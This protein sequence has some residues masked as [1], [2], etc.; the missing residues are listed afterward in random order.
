VQRDC[1]RRGYTTDRALE[2]LDHRETDAETYIRPQRRHAD[3]V[4]SFTPGDRG[5]QERLD[6]DVRLRP[7]LLHPDLS[8][9]ADGDRNSITVA[10]RKSETSLWVSG[11][12]R[13]ERSAAIQE[14]M[15]ERMHFASHLRTDRIGEF[16]AGTELHRSESLAITQLLVLYQ[17]VTARAAIAVGASHLRTDA[18]PAPGRGPEA[19]VTVTPHS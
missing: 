6:V 18:D 16:T 11:T 12:I 7:G 5:D 14:A 15:W 2:E 8:S 1:T 10:E 3:I 17:L 9:F 4:I 13:R 19:H